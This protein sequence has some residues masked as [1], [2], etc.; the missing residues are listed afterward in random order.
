MNSSDPFQAPSEP[1]EASPHEELKHSGLGI[2]SC[3]VGLM[4]GLFELALVAIAAVT[5][6]STPDRMDEDSPV[7]ILLGMGVFAG[8]AIA[9]LGVGLGIGGL[10]QR[11]KKLFAVLG[12]GIGLFITCGVAG[13]FVLSIM[14]T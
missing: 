7:V 12:V 11:R 8:L 4:A 1:F 14:M 2:A 5:A 6:V 10:V 13:W 3:V 9:M